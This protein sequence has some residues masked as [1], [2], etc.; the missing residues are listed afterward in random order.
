MK[1]A[2]IIVAIDALLACVA[3]AVCPNDPGGTPSLN[4]CAVAVNG[5]CANAGAAC[6]SQTGCVCVNHV[7]YTQCQCNAKE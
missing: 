5:Q 3:L 2:L 7:A 6:S 4:N 1:R